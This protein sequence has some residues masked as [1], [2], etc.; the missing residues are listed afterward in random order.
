[1][2]Q[3]KAVFAVH[4]KEVRF[5]SSGQFLSA[6]ENLLSLFVS[7]SIN[8]PPGNKNQI[9]WLWTLFLGM[10]FRIFNKTKRITTTKTKKISR[11]RCENRKGRN[12]D[13]H[14]KD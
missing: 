11:E 5:A 12:S 6:A 4:F 8:L 7:E 3:H 9:S 13:L 2:K 10:N 14:T 1:M